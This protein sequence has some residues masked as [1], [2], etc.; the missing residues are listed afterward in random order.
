[1]PAVIIEIAETHP[2]KVGKKLGAVKTAAGESFG[3]WPDKLSA[4]RVG[5]RYQIEFDENEFNGRTYR[6]ITNVQAVEAT[7]PARRA[8]H[9]ATEV[10]YVEQQF[11]CALLNAAIA[12]GT[13]QIQTDALVAAIKTA[14]AAWAQTFGAS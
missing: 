9:C 12:A 14:R 2:P 1:V 8:A 7:P 4:L 6:K 10:D 13:L 11:V 5:G 3:I